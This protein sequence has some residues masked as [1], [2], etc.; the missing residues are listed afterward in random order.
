MSD[1]TFLWDRN[2]VIVLNEEWFD[3]E[4]TL[5]CFDV[6]L[7]CI[8]KCRVGIFSVGKHLLAVVKKSVMTPCHDCL[9]SSVTV[10]LADESL[11]RAVNNQF[12]LT[13]N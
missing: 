5:L 3:F 10:D 1:C 11:N 8:L 6:F 12:G 2:R 4:S 7:L 9:Y 13:H